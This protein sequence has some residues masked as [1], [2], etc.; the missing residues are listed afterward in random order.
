MGYSMGARVAAFM[1]LANPHR[2]SRRWCSAAW[3]SGMVDGAGECGHD[4]QLRCSRTIPG[5]STRRHAGTPFPRLRRPDQKRP[6][7]AGRLHK[8]VADIAQPEVKWAKSKQPTLV[9]V[10]TRDDIG[11]SP[12]ELAGLMPNAESFAHR[13]PRPHAGGRRQDASS[14]ALSEFLEEHPI[15]AS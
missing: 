13:G 2:A 8:N 6:C 4:C 1:A 11:G 9:A 15:S 5:W 12:D 7:R 3:A 10:G 14:S